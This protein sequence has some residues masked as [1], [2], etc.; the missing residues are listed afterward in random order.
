MIEKIK[1]IITALRNVGIHSELSTDTASKVKMINTAVLIAITIDL[2]SFGLATFV[3]KTNEPTAILLIIT[4]I[5]VEALVIV[6][7]VFFSPKAVFNYV[8]ISLT[9]LFT[10]LKIFYV[11]HWGEQFIFLIIIYFV[12]LLFNERKTQ[13]ILV[14]T[15]TLFYIVADIIHQTLPDEMIQLLFDT[16]DSRVYL[17]VVYITLLSFL[18]NLFHKRTIK[19]SYEQQALL[20]QLQQQNEKIQK[21]SKEVER[22]NFIASHDLK[23]PLRNIVSFIGLTKIKLKR[24]Q[25][26]EVPEQL[27]FVENAAEQMNSLIDDILIFSK[28]NDIKSY[29]TK[30][31]IN[32][33]MYNITIELDDFLQKNNG[34]IIFNAL[35]IIYTNPKTLKMVF[36]N[37]IK[38]AV[39]YNESKNPTVEITYFAD[40]QSHI[41]KFKDN[42]I[43]IEKEF[44]AQVFEYFKRLHT[45]QSYKGTG[46]GL[47]ICKKIIEK[48]GGKL[49][50]QSEEGKGSTFT[51]SLPL[52][53]V[54]I[55]VNQ[56]KKDNFP[57]NQL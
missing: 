31:D 16:K 19:E 25:F 52:N 34:Q 5:L 38:N 26:H 27:D 40:N 6:F 39:L 14:T 20:K 48:M 44:Q 28:I 55:E 51:V 8:I 43:G 17:F 2:I 29:E 56:S 30:V 46:L 9:L 35:P 10:G 7:N 22:F 36:K 15:I 4:V 23:S 13:F 50:L 18:I 42:G 57:V 21:V 53:T 12:F 11:N 3:Y 1:H 41:F 54:K 32:E 45:Y 33:L 24:K 47:G 37:F 49:S